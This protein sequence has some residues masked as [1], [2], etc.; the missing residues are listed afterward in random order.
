MVR[1]GEGRGSDGE[2]VQGGAPAEGRALGLE[3]PC[4]RRY[5]KRAQ[6]NEP[7]LHRAVP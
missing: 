6:V 2:D 4:S 1:M 3:E 5:R 7:P